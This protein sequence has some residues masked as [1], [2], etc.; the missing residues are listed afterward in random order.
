MIQQPEWLWKLNSRSEYNDFWF[1]AKNHSLASV[2]PWT[3]N[4]YIFELCVF[5]CVRL[6]VSVCVCVIQSSDHA[7]RKLNRKK[8]Y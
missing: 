2:T 8:N 6:C 5:A 3:C 4:F 1:Y 7:I